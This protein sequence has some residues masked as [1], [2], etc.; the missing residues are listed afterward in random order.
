MEFHIAEDEGTKPGGY[1]MRFDSMKEWRTF[2]PRANASITS[3]VSRKKRTP[4]DPFGTPPAPVVN[5]VKSSTYPSSSEQ[6]RLYLAEYYK[7][8][9]Y[10][11]GV[12]IKDRGITKPQ[13]LLGKRTCFSA[14]RATHNWLICLHLD[15]IRV[16]TEMI[17]LSSGT[18][19]NAFYSDVRSMIL[20][21]LP[22]MSSAWQHFV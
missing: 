10:C 17:S 19:N 15:K 2:W 12:K 4:P 9:V 1:L 21:V 16:H 7:L 3:P 14:S 22:G 11:Q 5:P 6:A 18:K 8:I 13:D 20:S